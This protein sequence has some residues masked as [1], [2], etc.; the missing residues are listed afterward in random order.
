MGTLAWPQQVWPV[1][2][3]AP[4]VCRGQRG[5]LVLDKALHL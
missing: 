3:V 4:K 2:S 5:V 1:L